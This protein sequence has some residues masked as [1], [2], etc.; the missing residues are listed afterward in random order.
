MSDIAIKCE[1]LGKRYRVFQVSGWHHRNKVEKV[2]AAIHSP[3]S[4]LIHSLKADDETNT[5]W[6]L[7]D[8]SAEIKRG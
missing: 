7:K 5:I 4:W 1:G 3:F 2:T 8:F 6:A